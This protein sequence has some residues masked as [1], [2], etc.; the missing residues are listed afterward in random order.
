MN[1]GNFERQEAILESAVLSGQDL[2][3]LIYQGD[4]LP[5]DSR[6]LRFEDGGVFK[7]FNIENLI[8]P[9]RDRGNFYYPV[10][11]V[12]SKIVA[13]C[14]LEKS[15]YEENTYWMTGVSVDKDYQGNG[16]ASLVLEG[17]FKFA[18]ERGVGLVGS[19]YSDEGSQKLKAVLSRLSDEYGVIFKES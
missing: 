13:L 6:F 7:Y 4:S 1:E 5:K 3:E 9:H 19:R 12:D 15:P 10:V 18:K 14:E 11:K 17:A 2:F 16:Y 8:N